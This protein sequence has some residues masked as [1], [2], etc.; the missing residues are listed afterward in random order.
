MSYIVKRV[1]IGVAIGLIMMFARHAFALVPAVPTYS[2]GG[3]PFTG[4]Q[5]T[6]PQ[7]SPDA[8]CAR[9]TVI[10]NGLGNAGTFTRSGNFC[11]WTNGNGYS[12]ITGAAACPSNSTAVSGGCSCAAGFVENAAK[13]ACEPALSEAEKFCKSMVGNTISTGGSGSIPA[14]SCHMPE[15]PFDAPEQGKGCAMSIGDAVKFPDADGKTIWSGVGSWMGPT[16]TPGATPEAPPVE[17]K[18]DKC[19]GGFSGTVNNVQRCIPVEPDKGIEGVKNSSSTDAAGVKTDVKE[20]TRCQGVNCTTTTTTTKTPAGGGTPV[21][22]VT[23]VTNVLDD[24]CAKD[25][26][27][28]VCTKTGTTTGS[29]GGGTGDGEGDCEESDLVKCMKQGTP[30]DGEIPRT[31]KT[32]SLE[33][34]SISGFGQSCPQGSTFDVYGRSFSLSYQSLCDSAGWIRPLIL[35]VAA[36]ASTMIV[37]QAIRGNR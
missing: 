33:T 25:P 2:N 37:Y 1:L 12:I 7:S 30:E 11:M 5:S 14:S 35:L 4:Q 31:T 16:C 6:G 28:K 3:S 22:T 10:A 20:E 27:N 26:T 13:T 29:V 9:M 23:T 18:E 15:P 32:V 34:V 24:K 36:L 8:V 17:S 19:P 21:T